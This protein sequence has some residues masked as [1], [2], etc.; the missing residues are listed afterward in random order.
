MLTMRLPG[1]LE[2]RL[3]N[4]SNV[5]KRTKTSYVLEL[6]ESQIDA[7]EKKYLPKEESPELSQDV[8][9]ALLAWKE[10]DDTGLHVTWDE[11]KTWMNS[12][13]SDN[14]LPAPVCHK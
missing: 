2:T 9:E 13:F 3:N 12:W 8:Q 14:E 7:L 1:G 10:Y 11:T 4:L 6:L 5:T